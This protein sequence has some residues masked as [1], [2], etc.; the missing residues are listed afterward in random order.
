MKK[1]T[2]KTMHETRP[3]R[4]LYTSSALLA[5]VLIAGCAGASEDEPINTDPRTAGGIEYL[6]GAAFCSWEAR[7][8]VI[9][10]SQVKACTA[11]QIK[12]NEIFPEGWDPVDATNSGRV[13]FDVQAGQACLDAIAAAGCSIDQ[14]YAFYSTC[15]KVFLASVASGGACSS[16]LECKT[17][18]CAQA[19]GSYLVSDGCSGTCKEYLARGDACN[20]SNPACGSEDMCDLSSNKCVARAATGEPCGDNV[21]LCQDGLVCLGAT[22]QQPGTCQVR[23]EVG[24]PC[25][26][27]FDARTTT[28]ALGLFCDNNSKCAAR[29]PVGSACSSLYACDDGLACIGL[30]VESNGNVSVQGTCKPFLNAGAS[31]NPQPYES[32]CSQSTVCSYSSNTCEAGGGK[33]SDCSLGDRCADG[34]YCSADGTCQE[35]VPLGADCMPPM[36]SANDPCLVG[37]CD[38]AT[39]ICTLQCQ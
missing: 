12:R 26:S 11:T 17:G 30:D 1:K 10:A 3:M 4:R 25:S 19:D 2:N 39:C 16:I 31:C 23:G 21:A 34:T 32:G 35:R 6:T 29:L 5:I 13:T 18:Y 8:G 24:S 28:C 22:L 37:I 7:C 9:D 15:S 20:P 38:T 36:P 27:F 14:K 33:G